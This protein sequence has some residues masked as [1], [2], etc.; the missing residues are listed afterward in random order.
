MMELSPSLDV[1]MPC[2]VTERIDFP[3]WRW[4]CNLGRDT[5]RVIGSGIARVILQELGKEDSTGVPEPRVLYASF[6]VERID[7][8]TWETTLA[9]RS[10]NEGHL[11]YKT[12]CRRLP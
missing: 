11:Q 12:W 1:A 3:W 9:A 4:F 5:D 8:S 7:G 2:D 10:D 6:H